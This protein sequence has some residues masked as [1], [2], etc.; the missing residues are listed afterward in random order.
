MWDAGLSVADRTYVLLA[1]GY[2][3]IVSMLVEQEYIV[4]HLLSPTE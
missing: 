2:V 3:L 1:L 4:K